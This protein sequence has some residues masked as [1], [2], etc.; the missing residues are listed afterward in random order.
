MTIDRRRLLIGGGAGAGLL[1]GWLAWPRR[2]PPNLVAGPG[3][4][5][6][7][8]WLK[9]G[10][11]GRVMVAVPQAEFGQGSYTSLAQIVADELGAD[12]RTV[13]VEAAP[14]NPLYANP[15][16]ATQFGLVPGAERVARISTA[17]AEEYAETLAERDL[18]MLSGAGTTIRAFEARCRAAGAGARALLCKAAAKRWKVDWQAC[19]TIDGFVVRGE[20]RIRFADLA[21]EAAALDLPDP[22]PL[23]AG[24]ENRLTGKSVPR[25]DLPAKVDGSANYAGDIRLP[26]L[27]HCAV[28]RG[29]RGDTRLRAIDRAAGERITGV[30][31][32]VEH[33]RWVA[34]AG[35]NWWAANRA[36]DAMRPRFETRG[37]MAN[38]GAIEAALATALGGAGHRIAAGGDLSAAF[39][40]HPVLTGQYRAMLAVHAAAEPPS[41]TAELA[42]GTLRLWIATQAPMAVRRAAAMAAGLAEAAVIVHPTLGAGGFGDGYEV[43]LAAQAAHLALQLKRPVQLRWS[44][45]EAL[46]QDNYRPAAAAR[47]AARVDV[48]GR[49][50]GWQA[51]IAIPAAARQ[52]RA[53]MAGMPA[54]DALVEARTEADALA[55]EGA[56]PPY[57]VGAFAIDHHPADIGVPAGYW[58]GGGHALTSF[59]TECF[60]DELARARG[61]D[62]FDFRLPLLGAQ[63][64]LAHCLSTAAALGGWDG[65]GAGSRHGIACHAMRGSHV[66]VFAEARLEGARRIRVDRLIAVVDCGRV[67]HPDLVRQQ[68]E[69]GLVTGMADALGMATDI[70]GGLATARRLRDL[71]MPRL[72]DMPDIQV[73]IVASN[74][75]P[76]GVSDIVAPVVA[77]AIAN[78]L[79]AATGRR[80]RT[81]P[82]IMMEDTE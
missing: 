66:A 78:A 37:A 65:G 9:I 46:L 17:A 27:V 58:R 74:A 8:A 25:I 56:V 40:G 42:D 81:L 12:W 62:P 35:T 4:A 2:Y 33:E 57:A 43:E 45:V 24:E 36:L 53:R 79:R 73:E 61:L 7:N 48:R 6:F 22:I 60:I 75:A 82:L 55:I 3:E 1:V 51:K 18:L 39:A 54:H 80:A 47:M 59:F 13:G 50:L 52:L 28:R 38:G 67:I 29:P 32:V 10:V 19:D 20:D 23:R 72:A 44:R 68:I 30:L 15:L 11:D 76:G 31:A 49:I 26:G 77:P 69:S 71:A 34:A 41:A 16:L 63:R 5:V 64:R 14:L 70:E 21:A